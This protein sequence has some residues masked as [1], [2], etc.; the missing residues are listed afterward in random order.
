[1]NAFDSQPSGLTELGWPVLSRPQVN[2]PKGGREPAP[3]PETSS[4]DLCGTEN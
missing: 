3:E 2:S 4:V 1:M